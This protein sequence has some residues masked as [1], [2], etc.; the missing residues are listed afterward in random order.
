MDRMAPEPRTFKDLVEA[1]LRRAARLIIK[2]QDEIDPQFRI[3]TREGDYWIAVTLPAEAHDR[4]RMLRQLSTFM[5]WKEARAF[6]MACE[7]VVPDAVHCVGVTAS[8]RHSCFARI[9]REPRPWTAENFGALEWLA[10][11]SIDPVIVDLLPRG[12]RPMTPKEIS[13]LEKWFGVSGRFPAVHIA[14][15]EVR[16]LR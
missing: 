13:A 3:A 8:E 7:T 16:G 14:T 15:G 5:A 2:I 12:P 11:S 4:A 9:K 1:D 10:S 6:S